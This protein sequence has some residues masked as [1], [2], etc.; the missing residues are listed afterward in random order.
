MWPLIFV[1]LVKTTSKNTFLKFYRYNY[2]WNWT[3]SFAT[4]HTP[5]IHRFIFTVVPITYFEWKI[6]LGKILAMSVAF[7]IPAHR[8]VSM[9]WAPILIHRARF[10]DPIKF[11]LIIWTYNVGFQLVLWRHVSS[12]YYV[13]EN[14][15]LSFQFTLGAL[16]LM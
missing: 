8:P 11:F 9:E 7:S 6:S 3:I 16:W 12:V 13:S 15:Y 2:D 10:G 5:P 1:I 4:I 14:A